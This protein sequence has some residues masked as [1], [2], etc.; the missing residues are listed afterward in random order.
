MNPRER[1]PN[2][3]FRTSADGD[4][5]LDSACCAPQAHQR[6]DYYELT[7]EGAYHNAMAHRK[8][9]QRKACST[10]SDLAG[11]LNSRAANIETLH[12]S[13]SITCNREIIGIKSL[14]VRLFFLDF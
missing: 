12:L 7:A 9:P 6:L 13:I 10:S 11:A 14:I 1:Y 3:P 5:W 2:T 8:S 4:L